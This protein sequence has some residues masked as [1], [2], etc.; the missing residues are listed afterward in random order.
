[1]PVVP[2][3][4][5]AQS[6]TNR[7]GGRNLRWSRITKEV[8]VKE[9]SAGLLKGSIA[10]QQIAADSSMKSCKTKI[11]LNAVSGSAEPGQVISLMGPSGSGKTTL[12]DVLSGRS[13]FDGGVIT[14][15]GEVVDE[16]IMKKLKK[17]VS[18][19]RVSPLPAQLSATSH[20]AT[21]CIRQ[22]KRPFLW[23]PDGTRPTYLHCTLAPSLKM[24]KVQENWRG[25][26]DHQTATTNQVPRHTYL[27]DFRWR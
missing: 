11:I 14:L 21:G 4:S 26:Q 16:R 18:I 6:K 5:H 19:A 12:L 9:Q 1:M 8:Q 7:T 10:N 23:S 27:P 2:P 22:A 3:P 24:A 13:S 15:D 17:K 20:L 25:R